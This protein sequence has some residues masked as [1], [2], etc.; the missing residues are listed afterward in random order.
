VACNS[1][2]QTQCDQLCPMVMGTDRE[3]TNP[4]VCS[5]SNWPP[6]SAGYTQ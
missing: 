6:A 2:C 3:C 1:Y 5:P 4:A